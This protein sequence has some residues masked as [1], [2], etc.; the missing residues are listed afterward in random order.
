MS[1][2]LYTS[3]SLQVIR[4][5]IY[6]GAGSVNLPPEPLGA[7]GRRSGRAAPPAGRQGW[8]GAGGRRGQPGDGARG[9]LLARGAG[10]GRGLG[11]KTGN[12][13]AGRE[14]GGPGSCAALVVRGSVTGELP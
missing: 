13:N 2:L 7:S 9:R 1:T 12:G 14:R 8:S 4:H 11:K 10:H 6:D 3:V 5:V